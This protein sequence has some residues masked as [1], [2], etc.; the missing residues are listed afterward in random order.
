MSSSNKEIFYTE[1]LPIEIDFTEA[2]K[3]SAEEVL[4]RGKGLDKGSDLKAFLTE[5]EIKIRLSGLD[6]YYTMRV[7]WSWILAVLLIS[8]IA[9]QFILVLIIG[10]N[11]LD[12]SKNKEFL[13]LV[14]GE[15]FVQ[16]IGLCIII[17]NFLFYHSIVEFQLQELLLKLK[18]LYLNLYEAF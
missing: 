12:F 14:T 5:A 9:F 7:R 3:S 10:K 17:V 18:S 1:E 11:W 13:L 8:S 6:A 16:I 2:D 15:N 4:S